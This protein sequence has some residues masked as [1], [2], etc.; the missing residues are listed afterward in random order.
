MT[1]IARTAGRAG[2]A[3]ALPTSGAG[4]PWRAAGAALL[5]LAL[6]ACGTS[7]ESERGWAE[8]GE[9]RALRDAAAMLDSPRAR[10]AAPA[11]DGR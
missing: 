11:P 7:A 6:L 10:E 1:G 5:P 3:G 4:G 9:E 2:G 8:A